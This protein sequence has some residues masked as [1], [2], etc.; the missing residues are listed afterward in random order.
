MVVHLTT[1]DFI[2]LAALIVVA[3][4][5]S[6]VAGRRLARGEMPARIPAYARTIVSWL[7]VTATML[8]LWTR[9]DRP[10]AELGLVLRFDVR[11]FVGATL[12]VM[13]VAY[14]NGQLRVIGRMDAAK[15][16]RLAMAFGQ[17]AAILPRTLAEYRWFLA[18]S[19]TAGCCEELLYR[20]YLFAVAAPYVTVAGVLIGG[21]I[22][23]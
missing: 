22:V 7:L 2:L 12:C 21:A 19:L 10:S 15:R 5:Y 4:A 18:L 8:F 17:T 16:A 14:I 6:Y 1:A 13:L 23:F 3:P 9:L 11:A 20:G